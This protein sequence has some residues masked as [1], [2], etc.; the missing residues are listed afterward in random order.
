MIELTFVTLEVNFGVDGFAIFLL[1]GHI[2][3]NQILIVSNLVVLSVTLIERVYL[4]WANP[5]EDLV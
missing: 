2:L 3:S 5:D 4:I 1:S